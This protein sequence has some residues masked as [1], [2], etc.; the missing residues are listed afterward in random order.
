MGAHWAVDLCTASLW[1]PSG[2]SVPAGDCR[3]EEDGDLLL[4]PQE[5]SH[6]QGDYELQGEPRPTPSGA[7]HGVRG[8]HAGRDLARARGRPPVYEILT[9]PCKNSKVALIT[10]IALSL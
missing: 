3:G 7:G 5:S 4:P 1:L 8:A 6:L 9:S 2:G 10:F